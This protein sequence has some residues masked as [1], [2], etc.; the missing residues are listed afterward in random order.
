MKNITKTL[1]IFLLSSFI[2]IPVLNSADYSSATHHF[3]IPQHIS[4]NTESADPI[5]VFFDY[6]E[7]FY[8]LPGHEQA[9]DIF[10]EPG[11]WDPLECINRVTF[12]FN[13]YTARWI[14]K[15]AAMIYSFIVPEYV[16]K[17]LRRVDANI[18]MPGRLVNSLLQLNFTRAG[19]ELA[20]F[21]INTTLGIAGFYDPAYEWFEMQP[22]INDFAQTFA[23]W[24]I[25]KGF[26]L[27]LPV[28]GGTC[29]RDT[30]GLVG[31]Y[32]TNPITYIP[33]FF[34]NWTTWN[35]VTWLKIGVR[36]GLIFN[37]MT[38]SLDDYLRLCQSSLD[39]YENMKIVWLIISGIKETQTALQ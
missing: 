22:V 5:N 34:W 33:P 28:Y 10:D 13:L 39:P 30:V 14:I 20:R 21:G 3:T 29:L 7:A 18:Q 19:I 37:N 11:V 26:Y 1:F 27:I 36:G 17:G 15:P 8:T 32:F 35:W 2:L 9:T 23:Y 38:L 31:D 6:T 16:R 4:D 12:S 25:G 24:G